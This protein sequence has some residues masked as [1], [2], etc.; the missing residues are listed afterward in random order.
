MLFLVRLDASHQKTEVPA[1]SFLCLIGL[2][3]VHAQY[4]IAIR[5][6]DDFIA[7]LDLLA[8]IHLGICFP[9][10]FS[11]RCASPDFS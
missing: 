10:K 9:C 11:T 6:E 8:I 7:L 4:F 3:E 1:E 5:N 2:A